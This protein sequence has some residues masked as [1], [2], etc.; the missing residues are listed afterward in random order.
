MGR[1]KR[2]EAIDRDGVH[3][4]NEHRSVRRR[5]AINTIVTSKG[6]ILKACREIVAAEGLPA[7]NM[8]AVARRCNVALGSIYNY[9]PSKDE[10]VL[11]TIGSV[12]QDIFHMDR[13]SCAVPADFPG[14]VEWIFKSVKDGTKEYPD[15]F[16][17]HSL[18]FASAAKSK[19]TDAMEEYFTHIKS[20][21]AQALAADHAVRP[22]AFSPSFTAGAFIDFTFSSLLMLLVQQ[23]DSCGTLLEV[24]R[25]TL[26]R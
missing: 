4:Y 3:R 11:A 19:A 10:L 12:W 26:Y 13:Q 21:M 17:A 5:S 2:H 6:A 23:R 18:S 16:A 25:R 24:I 14:Y 1:K 15:F 9:F 7:L 8:R 22:D 20:G